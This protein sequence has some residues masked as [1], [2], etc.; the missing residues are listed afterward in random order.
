MPRVLLVRE[1]TREPRRR[2]G[3]PS[4]NGS[5][6]SENDE[7]QVEFGARQHK[8]AGAQHEER[9]V[10]SAA[11]AA[12]EYRRRQARASSSRSDGIETYPRLPAPA[13]ARA[14]QAHSSTSRDQPRSPVRR[15]QKLN[16]CASSARTAPQLSP[17]PSRGR[18][19]PSLA[20]RPAIRK[21]STHGYE[22]LQQALQLQQLHGARRL[23]REHRAT[24]LSR[25]STP[26]S[27]LEEQ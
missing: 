6:L 23:R 21:R 14:Q 18:P 27:G 15:L 16:P 26:E 5:K 20:P 2:R 4:D 19:R 13:A 17:W 22:P 7:V 9:R 3:G 25:P 10:H 24:W 12:P 8:Y 1:S 11:A